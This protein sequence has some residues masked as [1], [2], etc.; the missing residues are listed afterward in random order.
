[1][2]EAPEGTGSSRG[3]ALGWSVLIVFYDDVA[4]LARCL[5]ALEKQES[6]GVETIV[7]DHRGG[8]ALDSIRRQYP[9]VRVLSPGRNLGYGAGNNLA[10]SIAGGDRL[11]ILNPDVVAR[12]DMLRHLD[13]AL[14]SLPPCSLLTPTL[15]LPDGA[16][17]A[18]GNAVSYVG[19]ASCRGLGQAC[20]QVGIHRVAA[21]SGAAVALRRDLF[22]SLGGFDERFFLYLEDTD[23]SLRARLRGSACWC[24]GEA[25]AEHDYSW[26]LSPQKLGDLELNRWQLLLKIYRGRTL[27]ALA[28]GLLLAEAAT[29]GYAVSRGPAHVRAKLGSYRQ[30]FH[31]RYDLLTRRRA[32]QA[33]RRVGDGRLLAACTYRLPLQQ[34]L[35]GRW[36]RVLEVL[37]TPMLALPYVLARALAS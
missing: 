10:A 36:A 18:Q 24:A 31:L 37:I 9:N 16:V 8:R 12:P 2:L 4:A 19:L 7:V 20:P 14:E 27:L 3:L 15:L 6:V 21:A 28:P 1:M 26:D 17:N 25:I 22:R 5:Q 32:V 11:L 23:L 34:P 30:L 13:D 29:L 35:G 33:T